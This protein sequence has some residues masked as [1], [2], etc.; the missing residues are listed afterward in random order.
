MTI[1]NQEDNIIDFLRIP[2]PQVERRTET[3]YQKYL[4]SSFSFVI[5]LFIL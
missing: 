5:L 3:L 2:R 1:G 4:I